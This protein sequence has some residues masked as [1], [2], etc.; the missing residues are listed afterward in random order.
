MGAWHAFSRLTKQVNT[1]MGYLSAI[2]ICVATC[3][4]VFEV[5]VRYVFAWA[6][7]WEIEFSVILLII[8]TFMSAAYTQLTRGHVAIELLDEI[9]PPSWTR[10]RRLLADVVSFLFC[11]FIAWRIWHLSSDAWVEGRVSASLW[12]PKL[13][14]PFVFMAIGMTTLTLQLFIQIVEDE[15]ALTKGR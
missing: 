13:W 2:V 8:A 7:D 15:L 14:V 1:L 3:T 12:G 9:T 10:W 11:A 6:T 4:L 5:V